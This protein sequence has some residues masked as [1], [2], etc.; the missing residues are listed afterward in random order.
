MGTI[1]RTQELN[2]RIEVHARAR[3]DNNKLF[4]FTSN[5]S[6]SPNQEREAERLLCMINERHAAKRQ[7]LQARADTRQS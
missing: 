2:P 4:V 7:V 6:S 3:A 5:A 1:R